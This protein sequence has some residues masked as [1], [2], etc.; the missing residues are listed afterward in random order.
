MSGN[1]FNSLKILYNSTGRLKKAEFEI[2]L[3]DTIGIAKIK[4]ILRKCKFHIT[5]L[6][7]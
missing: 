5:F 4:P 2:Y 1:G 3:K 6:F 7:C